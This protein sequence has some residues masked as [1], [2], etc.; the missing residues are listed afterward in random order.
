MVSQRTHLCAGTHD[1]SLPDLPLR[2]PPI[3]IGSGGWI[4]ADA[5]IGPGVT[6]HDNSVVGA[7]AVVTKD[8]PA[9]MVV[10]GNPARVVKTRLMRADTQPLTS[11]ASAAQ[12]NTA[13]ANGQPLPG[14]PQ[15]ESLHAELEEHSA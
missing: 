15:Q 11:P 10:A 8:V 9:G 12:I 7:R 3:R 1:Y 13:P 5:F 6:V 2:R 4:C 14:V